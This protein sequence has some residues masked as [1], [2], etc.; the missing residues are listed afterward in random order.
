[1]LASSCCLPNSGSLAVNFCTF[2]AC[3]TKC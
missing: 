2:C 3:R 1:V